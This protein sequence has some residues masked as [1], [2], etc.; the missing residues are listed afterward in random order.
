LKAQNPMLIHR[1][2]PHRLHHRERC[3]LAHG[4]GVFPRELVC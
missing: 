4:I 2:R 1:S 3:V